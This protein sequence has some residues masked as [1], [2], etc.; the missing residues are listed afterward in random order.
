MNR[1]LKPLSPYW[2]YVAEIKFDKKATKQQRELF[3]LGWLELTKGEPI[4]AA[5]RAARQATLLRH[6]VRGF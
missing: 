3:K 6:A 4:I 5:H 2:E 1:V